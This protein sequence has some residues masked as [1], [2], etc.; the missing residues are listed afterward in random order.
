MLRKDRHIG[1]HLTTA[2]LLMWMWCATLTV[3]ARTR[4][5]ACPDPQRYSPFSY[6]YFL[7]PD[8]KPSLTEE[9]FY[10]LSLK[11][12]FPVNKYV[13][14]QDNPVL[15]QL[16]D[17][18]IPMLN[19][20]SLELVDVMMRGAASPEG[21]WRWNKFLGEHRGQALTMKGNDLSRPVV[22]S[23]FIDQNGRQMPDR[24]FHG[25][26]LHQGYLKEE[27]GN[28]PCKQKAQ[29]DHGYDQEFLLHISPVP[30]FSS[31]FSFGS[32]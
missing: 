7:G 6:L 22:R 25:M 28:K 12:I 3:A 21:P 10:A 4:L 16:A 2:L 26:S 13:L 1:K 27:R 29:C 24:R 19:R 9:E 8:E 15:R 20:D 11:V 30:A 5:D 18:V 32:P 23:P 14:P 17:E 31:Q